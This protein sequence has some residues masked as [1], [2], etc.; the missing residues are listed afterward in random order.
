MRNFRFLNKRGSAGDTSSHDKL[1]EKY[2]D[3]LDLAK[4]PTEGQEVSFDKSEVY[5]RIT[6]ALDQ[7]EEQAPARSSKKWIVAASAVVVIGL[8]GLM[9]KYR[10]QVLDLVDPI[11]Q[12]QLVAANGQIVNYTLADGTKVWLNGGSKLT[13]PESFRGSIRTVKVEGE[14]FFDVVHNAAKPFIVKAGNTRTQVLGT[15]FDVKAYPEDAFVKVDVATGKV[16]VIPATVAGKKAETVFLTPGE[17]VAIAKANNAATKLTGVDVT[18][19][20]GWRDGG[21][22]FRNMAVGEV[23]RAIEHRFNVKITVDQNIANCSI[24]ANFTN[25]SLKNIMTIMSRLVKGKAVADGENYRLK[26]KGC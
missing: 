4:Q 10:V 21:L 6:S 2:F 26:G 12:K 20:T 16:G 22:T 23:A 25:V 9:L 5:D 8:I 19:L 17:E 3:D 1:V 7:V 13:Y 15:S 14:A 11:P 24:S 18:M